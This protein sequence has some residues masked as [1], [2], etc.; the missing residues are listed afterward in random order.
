MWAAIRAILRKFGTLMQ[1]DLLDRCHGSKIVK[2]LKSKMAAAATVKN[3]KIA[4]FRTRFERFRRN[5]AQ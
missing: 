1:F 3:R 4:L 2:F 5:L